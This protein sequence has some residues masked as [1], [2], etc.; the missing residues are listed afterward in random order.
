[1]A[2]DNLD[3]KYGVGSA[4]SLILDYLLNVTIGISA[5]IGAIVSAI[6]ELQL[7]TLILCLVVLFLLTLVNLRGI[8]ETGMILVVTVI[9]F[10]RMHTHHSMYWI[11]QGMGDR[12]PSPSCS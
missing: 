2:S 5:G 10:Y 7:Y 6:P 11:I 12:W 9:L 4:I 1:M 8:R 3:K